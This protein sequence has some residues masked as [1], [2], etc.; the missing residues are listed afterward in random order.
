[1][2]KFK[3]LNKKG[4]GKDKIKRAQCMVKGKPYEAGEVVTLDSDSDA[5]KDLVYGGCAAPNDDSTKKS[6]PGW[7]SPGYSDDPVGVSKAV[8]EKK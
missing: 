3:I 7:K 4:F 6:F 8:S 5:A 2:G 1:M